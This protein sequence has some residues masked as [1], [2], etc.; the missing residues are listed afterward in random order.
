LAFDTVASRAPDIRWYSTVHPGWV[1]SGLPGE[2]WA[3]N[4]R[5]PVRFAD[6]VGA[7][8]T[9]GFDA[10]VEVS[11][12]P[13]LVAAIEE[14]ADAA[15]TEVSVTP[16]LRRGDGGPDRL[17]SALAQAW[18]RG[19]TVN[20]SN[21]VASVGPVPVMPT[22]PFQRRRYWPERP[23]TA[24]ASGTPTPVDAED[25]S[26]WEAVERTDTETL[27]RALDVPA[28][29]VP[30]LT[31][32]VP[33]LA[34]WRRDRER[35][36]RSAGWHHRLVWRPV[37]LTPAEAP[38]PRPWLLVVPDGEGEGEGTVVS[39]LRTALAAAGRPEPSVLVVGPD[40]SRAKLAERLGAATRTEPAAIVSTLGLMSRDPA[41]SD[42]PASTDRTVTLVQA[43]D[44]AAVGGPWWW[45]THRAVSTTPEEAPDAARAQL[46]GLGLVVGLD[47]PDR[48]GGVLD[49]GSFDPADL[50]AAVGIVGG[51]TG[52]EQLAV[53]AGRVLVRRL[54]AAAPPSAPAPWRTS[55]TAVVT[56]GTG[57]LGG[58][59]ARWLA[60]QG[61]EHLVLT[62]RR[63][64]SAPGAAALAEELRDLGVRVDLVACDL[65]GSEG[66]AALGA[67]LAGHRVRTVVHAAG[68]VEREAPLAGQTVDSVAAMLAAKVGGAE[69]LDALFADIE[70]DAFVLFSSGAATWGNVGG[71]SYA[72]ANAHLD[73]LAARRRAE[74][75]PALSVA[76]GAW[77]AGGMVD[78]DTA[79]ALLARGVREM[80]PDAALAALGSLLGAG[81]GPTA[82]VS[83][84]VWARFA[85]VYT[86]SRARRLLDEHDEVLR[87]RAEE[88]S[89]ST[90]IAD[91]APAEQRNPAA[92][93]LRGRL[94]R[95]GSETER[96]RIAVDV[97]RRTAAAALGHDLISE[98][99]ARR[100]FTELGFESLTAVD[101]RNRLA[102]VAG[103]RLPATAVYDHPTPRRLAEHLLEQLGPCSDTAD[104][105]D[106]SG[107]TGVLV[108][109]A[110]LES[111]LDLA[112]ESG[113]GYAA[114]E[115]LDAVVNRL[116]RLA[117]R[118][119]DH[120]SGPDHIVEDLDAVSDDEIFNLIDEEFGAA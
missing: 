68:V 81:V 44:D 41:G 61:A 72:A 94:G 97:V 65:A 55:G 50:S 27:T 96:V 71:A 83:D 35:R 118:H 58:R 82:V 12:H 49:L 21:F 51:D 93:G 46:W 15:G 75:R 18:T 73:A 33:A 8:L 23:T 99:G 67:A 100:S 103:V 70:L 108:A 32:V 26:F 86:A 28:E 87:I 25:A 22:Y 89:S 63:G 7:L 84:M 31:D 45:L 85:D 105:A 66:R 48:W 40:E 36:A 5:R 34:G 111:A 92:T 59:V 3:E 106:A 80:A 109:L 11:A 115:D 88:R 43:L 91:G 110:A 16:T 107:P 54:V 116:R 10:F 104:T 119:T 90:E 113:P 2:Y 53:R 38:D 56:G 74:G 19:A 9:A 117:D 4:L 47:H 1:D 95:A 39:A 76:W 77:A 69:Y 30:A 14:T 62:S 57:A 78:E 20:W 29:L 6:A 13:V 64:P 17:L 114:D 24:A 102:V 112:R 79:A 60:R 37:E 120:P 52:E 101:F 42:L 98:M